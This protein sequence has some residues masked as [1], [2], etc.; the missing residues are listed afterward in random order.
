MT[1]SG[2]AA[3]VRRPFGVPVV[4]RVDKAFAAAGIVLAFA[5]LT[6]GCA[7]LAIG[8]AAAG[9]AVAASEERGFGG[10][11]TDL[12][13]QTSINR[14]W[15]GHSVDLLNRLDMTVDSGRVL[16]IGRAKDPQQRLD[17]VRLAW[18]AAGVK[19]VIN[20]IQVEGPET[21]LIDSAKDTWISTQIRGRV[22]VDLSISS[23]NYTIDT[24]GGVV[25]LMGV[26]Q[27]QTELDAVL[28]HARSVGGVQ[29]VVTYVRLSTAAGGPPAPPSDRL[30]SDRP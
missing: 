25:Y 30:P 29:R 21:S 16:L 14:L 27:S 13:I 22:T 3:G 8:G 10:F 12:E 17:A 2:R 7:P 4:L 1:L 24:V 9:A 5:Q 19:E 28:Q 11:I 6:A 18:Q 20:E 23:Q 15:F 26:A